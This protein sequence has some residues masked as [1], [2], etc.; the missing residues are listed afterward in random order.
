MTSRSKLVNLSTL[1]AALNN[2][3]RKWSLTTGLN[4][5]WIN[6]LL[7][8]IPRKRKKTIRLNRDI[9]YIMSSVTGHPFRYYEVID[10]RLSYW[11]QSTVL[12]VWSNIY[13]SLNKQLITFHVYSWS[14]KYVV[15]KMALER[16]FQLISIKYIFRF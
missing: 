14:R 8:I 9:F 6:F 3:L 10:E 16:T 12:T 7:K 1:N 15:S 11:T 2:C 4:Y 5:A 13:S